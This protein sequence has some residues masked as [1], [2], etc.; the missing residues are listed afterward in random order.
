MHSNYSVVMKIRGSGGGE[1]EDEV[2]ELANLVKREL[3]IL[4]SQISDL[5][6]YLK[7]QKAAGYTVGTNKSIEEHNAQV[8]VS[9]QSRLAE[10]SSSFTVALEERSQLLRAQRSRREQFSAPLTSN[11]YS[12][13]A[14]RQ[15]NVP[16]PT[17]HVAIDMG[18]GSASSLQQLSLM[19]AAP[20][21]AYLEGRS[22]ALQGIESTIN[23]LGTIYRQLATM[24]AEQGEQV[25]RIDMNIESMQVNIE[26]G[27]NELAKYLRRVSS[28]R[29]L[30][31]KIFAVLII[32]V[33]FFNLFLI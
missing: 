24:I 31:V 22:N 33:I 4:N 13:P 19:T 16:P 2:D 15:R 21:T 32:F 26:R 5:Q 8:I 9:L 30:M 12:A 17:S 28:N 7:M 14:S 3:A 25:Q 1:G 29:W 27:Q 20:D 10:L 11:I 6:N 23:E 18:E